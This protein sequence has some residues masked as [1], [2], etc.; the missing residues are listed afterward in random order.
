MTVNWNSIRDILYDSTPRVREGEAALTLR[1]DP[2][3]LRSLY[4]R[5]RSAPNV[6]IVGSAPQKLGIPWF[7]RMSGPQEEIDLVREHFTKHEICTIDDW[8]VKE[9][10]EALELAA[11]VRALIRPDPRVYASAHRISNTARAL[12]RI[13]EDKVVDPTSLHAFNIALSFLFE[14]EELDIA[15]RLL[16]K[17]KEL[18]QASTISCFNTFLVYK[19]KDQDLNGFYAI[20]RRLLH[21]GL[22][23][24][25]ETWLAAFPLIPSTDAM[26]GFIAEMHLR[27]YMEHTNAAHYASRHVIG[28]SFGPFLD[29]GGSVSGYIEDLDALYG[30]IWHRAV[31]VHKLLGTL[32][33]RGRIQDAVRMLETFVSDRNYVCYATDINVILG[34]CARHLNGDTAV[35]VMKHA[36]DVWKVR[37]D[38]VTYAILFKLFRRARMYN[39]C[40]VVWKYACLQGQAGYA[41]RLVVRHSLEAAPG[42][43]K[44]VQEQWQS[45][46]GAVACGCPVGASTTTAREVFHKELELAGGTADRSL[47]DALVEALRMDKQWSMDGSR[48]GKDTSWKLQNA[49]AISISPPTPSSLA[50][51][52]RSGSHSRTLNVSGSVG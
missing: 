23:P 17:W 24:T 11:T 16:W 3:T 20:L 9:G 44:S 38:R 15:R 29:K 21:E 8:A 7:H 12:E 27:G 28:Y 26:Q 34:N 43:A 18:S 41:M 30:K 22:T 14:H 4:E 36:F 51:L 49:I 2:S 42:E 33:E 47:V 35:A 6:R 37:P 40:R 50:A 32:G 31:A 10:R 52:R 5:L 19:A 1:G 25:W 13:F 45:S 48:R 46:F 39:S